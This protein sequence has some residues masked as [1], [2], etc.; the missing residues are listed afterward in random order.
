MSEKEK[1]KERRKERTK[2]RKNERKK[3]EEEQD[4]IEI[5]TYRF[6]DYVKDRGTLGVTFTSKYM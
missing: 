5:F 3:K 2:E 4:K 1:K 6:H